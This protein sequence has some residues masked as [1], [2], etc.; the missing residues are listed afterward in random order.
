MNGDRSIILSVY[1]PLQLKKDGG[2]RLLDIKADVN[3]YPNMYSVQSHD[4]MYSKGGP[5]QLKFRI[6]KVA[7]VS[8]I[9]RS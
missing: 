7:P 9:K 1:S 8:S 3:R 6:V 5:R 4:C 2:A